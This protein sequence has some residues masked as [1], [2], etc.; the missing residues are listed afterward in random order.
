MERDSD[1]SDT[2][3]Q[4]KEFLKTQLSEPIEH[5]DDIDMS[6]RGNS[7]PALGRER[8]T[9]STAHR[10]VAEALGSTEASKEFGL[11]GPVLPNT[12]K[13]IAR[14]SHAFGFK[15]EAGF[16]SWMQSDGFQPFYDQLQLSLQNMSASTSNTERS[17]QG[18]Q[19]IAVQKALVAG[20][21]FGKQKYSR[22][23]GPITN[24]FSELDFYAL[25][26]FNIVDY[27]TVNRNGAFFNRKVS[28]PDMQA[29]VWQLILHAN[30]SNAPSRRTKKPTTDQTAQR[31]SGGSTD[32]QKKSSNENARGGPSGGS[33]D[34]QNVPQLMNNENLRDHTDN[35]KSTESIRVKWDTLKSTMNPMD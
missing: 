35:S 34:V 25:C 2:S 12:F 23:S 24:D 14:L 11:Y 28:V 20:E 4:I 7:D 30:H 18:P 31:F 1:M 16:T 15:S 6:D 32:R 19:L 9:R 22:R 17:R 8:I 13:S 10:S 26:L 29:R 3:S 27:N 5:D 33:T 21:S